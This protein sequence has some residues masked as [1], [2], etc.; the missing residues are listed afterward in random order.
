[1]VEKASRRDLCKTCAAPAKPKKDLI[2]AEIETADKGEKEKFCEILSNCQK[3]D[4][5]FDILIL[6][7]AKNKDKR[8]LYAS[9]LARFGDE[10][11]LPFLLNA[12]EDEKISYADFEELRFTI[13][14]LGGEYNKARD[15]SKDRSYN[16]IKK[17]KTKS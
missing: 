6:E 9:Y 1:M 3:D 17:D 14:A 8:Q 12:I 10:R 11:A 16:L 5:V 4:K 2:F 15:F 7:F 13:E